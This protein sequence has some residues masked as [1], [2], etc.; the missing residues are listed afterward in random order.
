MKLLHQD[1]VHVVWKHEPMLYYC[2]N[3]KIL[4]SS[5]F[6]LNIVTFRCQEWVASPSSNLASTTSKEQV[7][8]NKKYKNILV[9][10]EI[11][12][13]LQT[14]VESDYAGAHFLTWNLPFSVFIKEFWPKHILYLKNNLSAQKLNKL[15]KGETVFK[16]FIGI[17][18]LYFF[19]IKIYAIT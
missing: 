9:S 7:H 3:Y 15:C 6:D 1:C 2:I 4:L 16:L 19:V 12:K 18:L 13:S 8:T 5:V 10:I 14:S 11:T 17:P